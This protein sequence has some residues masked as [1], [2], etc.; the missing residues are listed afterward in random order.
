MKKTISIILC[1]VMIISPLITIIIDV[2][3]VSA[4]PGDDEAYIHSIDL[5]DDEHDSM[6]DKQLNVD[7]VYLLIIK[8]N[9]TSGWSNTEIEV[10]A[11]YDGGKIGMASNYPAEL[12]SHRNAAFTFIYDPETGTAWVEFPAGDLEVKI[13]NIR[14][15]IPFTN[16]IDPEQAIHEVEIY[17]YIGAQ[18]LAA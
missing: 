18:L 2:P 3:E 11:W 1:Y 5:L 8:A 14:D 17:F 13:I 7:R 10:K 9:S 6:L 4:L 16:S 12:E 15:T